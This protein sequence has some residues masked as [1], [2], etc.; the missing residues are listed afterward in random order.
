MCGIGRI[1]IRAA[2]PRISDAEPLLEGLAV[3]FIV[4]VIEGRDALLEGFEGGA[5]DSLLW[6]TADADDLA[7]IEGFF[8]LEICPDEGYEL[9]C[10]VGDLLGD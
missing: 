6:L 9:N 7:V 3:P 2:D 8:V 1:D 4:P 10:F 5:M